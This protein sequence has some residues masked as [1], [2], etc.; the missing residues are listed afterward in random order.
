M[1]VPNRHNNSGEYRYGFQ[2]QEKDDEI[3]GEG[4]S[5]NYT[6]RM[7]DPRVG[8]FLSRDPLSSEFP[9]NSPYAFSENR[10]I[11]GVELEGGEYQAAQLYFYA[12]NGVYGETTQKVAN[13]IEKGVKNLASPKWWA[14]GLKETAKMAIQAKSNPS[15]VANDI[16]NQSAVLTELF[17]SDDTEGKTQF[18]T[19]AIGSALILKGASKLTTIAPNANAPKVSL[20]EVPVVENAIEIS[21]VSNKAKTSPTEDFRVTPDGVAFPTKQE[22]MREGFDRAG[23]PSKP[24]TQ[25][26]EQGVI[27][28]VPTKKGKV[29]V[30]SMEGSASHPKRSVIT[31]P[32][33]NSPKTPSG[34]AGTKKDGHINQK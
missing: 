30:R 28:T 32:D 29:D 21:T 20:P 22:T 19:E 25:T 2:G 3:K 10:V 12:K 23:F 24:A 17:T 31:H 8:R 4:N 14:N 15:G 11:D 18:V 33:T 16:V 5:V 13:G 6:F 34:K 9:W 7:H 26:S 27:H 1:L